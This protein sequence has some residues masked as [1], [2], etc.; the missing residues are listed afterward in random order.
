MQEW[1]Q[2]PIEA[3]PSIKPMSDRRNNWFGI[4][5]VLAKDTYI[6]LQLKSGLSI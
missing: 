5:S 6:C 3:F 2:T 4:D 1:I